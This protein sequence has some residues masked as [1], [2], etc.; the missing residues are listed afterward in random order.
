MTREAVVDGFEQFIGDAIDESMSEFSITRALQNGV[1]GP[2]GSAVDQLL[3]NSRRLNRRVVEPELE[4]YRDR[5]FEQFSYILDYAE[6][7]DDIEAY[8]GDILSAGA[9]ENELREDLSEEKRTE[10]TDYMLGRHEALADQLEPL[11][12]SPEDDFWAAAADEMTA[13]TAHQLVEEHFAYAQPLREYPEAFRMSTTVNT[14]DVLGLVGTLLGGT[15][16]EVEYTDEAL[17]ALSLAEQSVIESAKA[18]IEE[19]FD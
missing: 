7:D 19:N 4:T 11:I 2:G 12:H 9:F 1:R 15:T 3:N 8:R 10:V 6:S 5:T 17:R 18:D 14:S 16:I 13:D